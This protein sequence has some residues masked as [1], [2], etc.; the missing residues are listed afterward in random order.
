MVTL[1]TGQ[2][3]GTDHLSQIINTVSLTIDPPKGFQILWQGQSQAADRM[4]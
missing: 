1:I 2:G 3:R 4:L